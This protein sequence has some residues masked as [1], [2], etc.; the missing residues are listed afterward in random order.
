MMPWRA[1]GLALLPWLLFPAVASAAPRVLVVLQTPQTVTLAWDANTDG[2]TAGYRVHIGTSKGT[3]PTTV[4][5]GLV[6]QFTSA[7][8]PAGP[9]YFVV[10]A[11]DAS[12]AETGPSNEVFTTS[13]QGDPCVCPLGAACVSIFIT[14]LEN[15]TGSVGSQARLNFQLGSPAAPI[16]SLTLAVN[17]VTADQPVV[18]ANL[19]KTGGIWF[20]TPLTAGTYPVTLLATN[21]SGCAAL[22]TKDALGNLLTVTVQ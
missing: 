8:L 10:T 15:T 6:T 7:I 1:W 21:S 17:D 20:T 19:T 11:Y 18:G 2:L 16:T 3:W 4:D 14:K 9:Y 5:V 13:G 22:A 12:G